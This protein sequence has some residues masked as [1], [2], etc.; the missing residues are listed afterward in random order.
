MR[1]ELEQHRTFLLPNDIVVADPHP[2]ECFDEQLVV[3][4]SDGALGGFP[5]TIIGMLKR[6]FIGRFIC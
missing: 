2:L 5:I 1:L 3:Y 4:F 6:A